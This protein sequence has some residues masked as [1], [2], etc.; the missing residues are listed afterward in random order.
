MRSYTPGGRFSADFETDLVQDGYDKDLKN[1]VGTIA[2][3]YIFDP[4][5]STKDPIYDTGGQDYGRSWRGPY[6]LP[7][8]R[9]VITQG[10]VP[11]SDRGFYNTDTLH[12]T[13]NA[14]DIENIDPNVINNIDLENRGRI[15]WKHQV[16]RPYYVQQRGI[17]AERFTLVVIDCMQVSPEEMVNDWQFLT[18]IDGIPPIVNPITP[19]YSVVNGIPGTLLDGGTP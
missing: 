7:I 2:D 11:Q 9:A 18:A 12:L 4:E 5:N 3:W 17:I 13:I 15:V 16:Y 10:Q 6:K 8:I 14:R 19:D 1:P